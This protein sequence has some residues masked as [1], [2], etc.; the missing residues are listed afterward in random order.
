[1]QDNTV[2]APVTQ[3]TPLYRF[4][5]ISNGMTISGLECVWGHPQ[6]QLFTGVFAPSWPSIDF[7]D[8]RLEPALELRPA[9]RSLRDKAQEA[10]SEFE[11]EYRW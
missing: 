1:M 11:R 8:E 4:T 6:S 9:H 2:F 10:M 3:L 7:P 5:S